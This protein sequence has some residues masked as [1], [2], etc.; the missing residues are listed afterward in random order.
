MNSTL[1]YGIIIQARNNS[2][3]LKNKISKPF[4]GQFT[5]LD[6][7]ISNL[8]NRFRNTPIVLATTKNE[9]DNVLEDIAL[10]YKLPVFRGDE[11][12]VLKRM[13]DAAVGNNIDVVVRICADNPFL[14]IES[15]AELINQHKQATETDYISYEVGRNKPAIMSHFGFY[16]ELASLNALTEVI[17][18]TSDPYYLEHVTNYIYTHPDDFKLHYIH[19]P[20]YVYDRTDIRLTVDTKEDFEQAQRLYANKINNGWNQHDLINFIDSN[21]DIKESMI[22]MIKSNTK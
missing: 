6:I 21:I 9:T 20:S 15:I 14:D 7:I 4:Y 13:I 16:A 5:I 3:R 11:Q 17:S 8:I 19:A 18:A 10:K 1:S 2:S 12:N 22:R